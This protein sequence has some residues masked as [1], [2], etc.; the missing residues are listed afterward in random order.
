VSAELKRRAGAARAW[1]FDAA[2]PL[3][4]GA[5]FDA[6]TG[7]FQEK[8]DHAGAP[9]S[10]LA[11]RMRVQTRQT[12]VFRQAARLGWP[13]DWKPLVR[14]GLETIA[15]RGR[16]E[17][18]AV[19]CAL[20]ETGKLVDP[21]RDLYDQAFALFALAHARDID[22]STV[23]RRIADLFAY[24]DTQ[25]GP[26]GGFLEGDVKPAP[27]WQNPHMHLFEAGIALAEAGIE[28]GMALAREIAGLFDAYFFD[29]ANGALGEYYAPDW[30]RAAGDEGRFAEP[31]HHCE[32]IW[33]LDR[34]RR[35]GGGE[36]AAPAQALWARVARDG[37][38][39]GVVID[40]IWRDDGP[41]TKTARL[42]PQTE[43]LKAALIRWETGAGG[44][45]DI[46]AA[47]DGLWRYFE[48]M[49]PGLWRD[50]MGEDGAFVEEPSPA[51]S[52]YHIVVALSELMRVADL[53]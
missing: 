11:R 21:R 23:D 1:L 25:V 33:L 34:W 8:L 49:R 42:W 47:Y 46:I 7:L 18:G 48:G 41:R 14:A 29:A 22:P 40:G 52:L 51:S 28:R 53:D 38:H 36:R 37:L 17:G 35:H 43:R 6:K 19:G 15:A 16:A 44:E 13:G 2:L 20:S 30:S 27:R 4:A 9:V 45:D 3:W 12:Y 5:G 32:W 10:G 39:R 31:G 26:N 24:L 50:R